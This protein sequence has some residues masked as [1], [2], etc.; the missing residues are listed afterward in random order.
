MR[1]D[2]KWASSLAW[3]GSI[4]TSK[5]ALSRHLKAILAT[6]LAVTTQSEKL[7]TRKLFALRPISSSEDV[8]TDV[9]SFWCVIAESTQLN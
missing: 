8:Q 7:C 1:K 4:K 9:Q 6:A 3:P 2:N 5:A